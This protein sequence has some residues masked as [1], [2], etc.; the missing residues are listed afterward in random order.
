MKLLLILLLSM[1]AHANDSQVCLEFTKNVI[2]PLL[3]DNE[4]G[5]EDDTWQIIKDEA[6]V[7]AALKAYD[8]EKFSVRDAVKGSDQRTKDCDSF[9]SKD[10]QYCSDRRFEHFFFLRGLIYGMKHHGWKKSTIDLGTQR[11][12]E[13]VTA[14]TEPKMGLL[15]LSTATDILNH[16]LKHFPQKG[17]DA[18]ATKKLDQEISATRDVRKDKRRKSP[19]KTCELLEKEL[20]EERAVA[21]P[22]R[23]RLAKVLSNRK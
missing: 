16:L 6:K 11:V 10:I 9:F 8:S 14:S 7:V 21:E 12:L 19:S 3:V 23:L 4:K 13:Y 22:F 20:Q 1:S 2:K 18:I 5:G 17:I 15:E